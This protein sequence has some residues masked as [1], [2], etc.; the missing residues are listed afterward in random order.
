MG[1]ESKRTFLYSKEQ[2]ATAVY[3]A[4]ENGLLVVVAEILIQFSMV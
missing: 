4:T 3:G 1:C 2:F